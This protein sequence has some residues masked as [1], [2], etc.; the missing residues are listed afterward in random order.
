MVADIGEHDGMHLNEWFELDAIN[1]VSQNLPCPLS[2]VLSKLV[3]GNQLW[4]QLSI[5]LHSNV[6]LKSE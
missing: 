3:V 6:L 5:F 4:I 1:S 2:I